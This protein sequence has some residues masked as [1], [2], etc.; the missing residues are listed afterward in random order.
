MSILNVNKINPIGGGSTITIA[1]IASVT[2]SV[3]VANSVTASSF[4]GNIT[5]VATGATKIYVDESEDDNAFYNIPFLD[6][7]TF[8]NQYHTLQ[9]DNGAFSFNPAANAI[10]VNRIT[11]SSGQPLQFDIGGFEKVRVSTGGNLGINSTAPTSKLDVVGDA[12]ISGIIT[13]SNLSGTTT[14]GG[15]PSNPAATAQEIKDA[16]SGTPDNGWYWIK[17]FGNIAYQHYCVFKNKA[18][19]DIA[20]GPWVVNFVAGVNPTFFSA[21]YTTA[22]VQYINLCKQIGIDQPGRGMESSRTQTEVRGAW[23]ASKRAIW[24]M[25]PGM[26][27][28]ASSAAGGVMIM[29][30]L[31]INNDGGSSD[32]RLV[33]NDSATHLPANQDGDACTGSQLFCGWW[34][35][36]DFT[37]WATDNDNVPGPED[38]GIGDSAHTGTIGARSHSYTV[39]PSWRFKMLVNCIYR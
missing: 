24:E 4:H 5:G 8:G 36:N 17:D 27:D 26:F 25:D 33:Y 14:I 13:A 20:G 12:K 30:M 2:N 21:T 35:G 32:Q 28:G 15:S 6:Q 3:S 10:L 29:P 22:K 9:V 11:P 18:G 23:L 34:G 37:S 39:K 7:N 38:W 16:V 31:N 1:G 19:S